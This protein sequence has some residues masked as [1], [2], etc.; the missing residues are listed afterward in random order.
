MRMRD[1]SMLIGP[2]VNAISWPI[3]PTL[4]TLLINSSYAMDAI[5]ASFAQWHYRS[6]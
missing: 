2:N 4:E 6:Q 5:I 3:D 1:F